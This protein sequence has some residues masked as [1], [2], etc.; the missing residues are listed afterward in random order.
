MPSLEFV[1]ALMEFY[2][3]IGM[4]RQSQVEYQ[5]LVT[6]TSKLSIKDRKYVYRPNNIKK[7]DFQ[8]IGKVSRKFGQSQ[9]YQAFDKTSNQL[10]GQF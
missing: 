3:E 4:N 5:R 9:P 8:N 7:E 6:K 10:N 2:K 1:Q